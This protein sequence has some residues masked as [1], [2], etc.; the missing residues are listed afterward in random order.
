MFV[1][2]AVILTF[3]TTP[4]TL[5]FYPEKYRTRERPKTNYSIEDGAV[6]HPSRDEHKTRFA[7][8]LDRIEQLPA[9]MTI[10]HLLQPDQTSLPNGRTSSDGSEKSF[11]KIPVSSGSHQISINALRLIELTN[12]GSALIKSQAAESL[13]Y[14][15]PIISVFRTF[16]YLD[17]LLVSAT[18]SVVSKD[19]FPAAVSA[20]AAE[21]ESQMIIVP[22]SRGS[23]EVDDESD[24]HA[25][26][27]FDGIFHKHTTHTSTRDPTSSIV[28]SEF[29]RNVFSTSSSNV[30]LFVDR[31][32]STPHHRS[33]T[34]HLFLPFIGGP[35]DRL[36]L[37][38]IVQLA[39]NSSVQATVIRIIKVEGSSR[40]NTDI[41]KK[42]VIDAS[43][44]VPIVLQTLAAGDTVYAQH[45]T[46]T[47]LASET[48]DNLTWDRYATASTSHDT[49]TAAALSRISFRTV[50]TATP[51]HTIIEYT[52]KVPQTDSARDL[53]VV[54]G[55]SRR[56]AVEAHAAELKTLITEAGASISSSV[57]KTLGDVGAA[58]VASNTRASLLIIQAT[59]DGL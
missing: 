9:A 17:N 4:L 7:L 56:M 13:A 25:H 49:E 48:A 24:N 47:R 3:L 31:G 39:R 26:N 10:A 12:R 55:R 44:S 28:Y 23:T 52:T 46:H 37:S 57:P 21:T 20:H 58:L 16:A 40:N 36:A 22:W 33:G 34:Q 19:E 11:E 29:I 51:L 45:D 53:I 41:D 2:H 38:F 1:V 50:E 43:S 5:L 27:P 6:S 14:T 42:D 30:A 54:S 59:I 32:I 35:D 15:D 8:V 18:L